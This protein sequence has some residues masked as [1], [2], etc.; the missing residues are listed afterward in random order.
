MIPIIKPLMGQEEV[1]VAA[2]VIL[3]V[4]LYNGLKLEFQLVFLRV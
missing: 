1:E 2:R 4:W 3:S